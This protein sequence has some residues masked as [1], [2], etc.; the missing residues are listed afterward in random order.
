VVELLA[1]IF[2]KTAIWV[3]LKDAVGNCDDMKYDGDIRGKRK[4]PS[5]NS[6]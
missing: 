2:S 1:T 6:Q 4:P 3:A 5:L